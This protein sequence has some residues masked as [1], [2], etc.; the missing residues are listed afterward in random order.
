MADKL[1]NQDF[2]V[3]MD[4]LHKLKQTFNVENKTVTWQANS[5]NRS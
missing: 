3:G 1:L 5:Q 4:I 2:I